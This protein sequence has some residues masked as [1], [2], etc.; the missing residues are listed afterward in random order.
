MVIEGIQT[1]PAI[2]DSITHWNSA[3][4]GLNTHFQVDWLFFAQDAPGTPDILADIQNAWSNFVKTGQIWALLIGI[5][6]GYLF[7]SMTSF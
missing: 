3:L 6:F 4:A 1:L 2:A 7:R 5:F